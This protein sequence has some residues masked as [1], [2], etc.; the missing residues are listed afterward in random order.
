MKLGFAAPASIAVVL[1]SGCAS[2][3]TT[4][5][6]M[7]D[8]E[9]DVIHATD[10]FTSMK[11]EL[12]LA[13][14]AVLEVSDQDLPASL[15]ASITSE[16][17][18]RRRLERIRELSRQWIDVTMSLTVIDQPDSSGGITLSVP[19]SF[20]S[21]SF[22]GN[23]KSSRKSTR[24][25]D[26]VTVLLSSNLQPCNQSSA[27]GTFE[28][29]IQPGLGLRDWVN[30]VVLVASDTSDLQQPKSAS[31]SVEFEIVEAVDGSL[32]LNRQK[33]N[34][35]KYAFSIA[36]GDPRTVKHKLTITTVKASPRA[37]NDPSGPDA[38][39]EIQALDSAA[40]RFSDSVSE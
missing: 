40:A 32:T 21:I 29:R 20:G 38:K 16:N 4:N 12:E 1:L 22:A 2:L 6:A 15:R 30:A 28:N 25:M 3:D 39:T 11:C 10:I 35:E 8:I 31:Y 24:T 19:V 5:R 18:R 36:G 13:Y 17:D 33:S 37:A 26:Y 23:A 14:R 9:E 27:S 34:T 7:S